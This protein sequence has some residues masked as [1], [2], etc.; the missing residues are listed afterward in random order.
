MPLFSFSDTISLGDNKDGEMF[1]IKEIKN[2]IKKTVAIVDKDYYAIFFKNG[3]YV[4]ILG[5]GKH[6]VAAKGEKNTF[7][8][9]IYVSMTASLSVKWAIPLVS[10]EAKFGLRGE[11]EVK[12]G[13][14]GKAYKEIEGGSAEKLQLKL[15][16]RI[17]SELP[18]IIARAIE[19]MG[20]EALTD[21]AELAEAIS[22]AISEILL[23]DY[24]L[25]LVGLTVDKTE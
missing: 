10:E 14:I 18:A 2:P 4:E 6:Q 24:G 8:L 12:I 17:C 7:V 13:D 22:P 3:A 16:N 5:E 9:L 23:K 19:E 11:L 1:I 21:N 15:K 25:K 20:K